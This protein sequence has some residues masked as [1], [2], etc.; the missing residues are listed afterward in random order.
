MKECFG[1]TSLLVLPHMDFSVA[2]FDNIAQR[3]YFIVAKI[4]NTFYIM[5]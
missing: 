4:I 3:K 2:L 5:L 1:G